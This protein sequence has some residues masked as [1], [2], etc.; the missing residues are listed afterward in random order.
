MEI[1]FIWIAMGIIGGVIAANK[2]R[3]EIGFGCLSLL[4]GPLG[5]VIAL[6]VSPN[7][8]AIEQKTVESGTRVRCWACAE[9]I[10]AE[11][12]KCRYCGEAVQDHG[13]T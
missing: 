8:P 9:L 4:L 5:I 6:C 3:S 1:L 7:T 11:A 10:R 12:L 13:E 2:G